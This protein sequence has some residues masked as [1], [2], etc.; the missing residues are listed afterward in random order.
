MTADEISRVVSSPRDLMSM[1]T[2]ADSADKAQIFSQPGLALTYHPAA[3]RY[4]RKRG[5]LLMY[6]RKRPR[7]DRPR[8]PTLLYELQS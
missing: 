8:I 6:V 7:G 2:S 5:P 1:R 4:G 3:R